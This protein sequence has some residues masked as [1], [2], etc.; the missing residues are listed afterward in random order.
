L[1]FVHSSPTANEKNT[2]KAKQ[3]NAHVNKQ[4]KKHETPGNQRL[5]VTNFGKFPKK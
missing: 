1:L 5:I 4:Q 3:Q 2:Q